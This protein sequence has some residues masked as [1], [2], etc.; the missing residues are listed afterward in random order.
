MQ[1]GRLLSKRN[2]TH[3]RSGGNAV[4]TNSLYFEN[5]YDEGISREGGIEVCTTQKTPSIRVEGRGLY[6]KDEAAATYS[7]TQSPAQYHGR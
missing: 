6:I 2:L 1:A 7:P 5:P 4:S 3:A